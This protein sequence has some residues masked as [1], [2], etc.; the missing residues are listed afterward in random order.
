[1]V[2]LPAFGVTIDAFQALRTIGC[3]LVDTT[4]GSV[5][6]V[7][8]RVEAYGRDG[9]TRSSMASTS[10]RRRGHGVADAEVRWHYIIVRHML[11]A[12]MVCDFIEGRLS[13]AELMSS[14][15]NAVS[16]DFDPD[17][18]LRRIGVA[19]QTT[20]LARES[21]AI[22]E[23]VGMAMDRARGA[24]ARANDSERSIRSA[25]PPRNV[26]TRSLNC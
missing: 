22:G 24:E 2:L 9:Y 15:A 17:Q 4:C 11:E 21:L 3:V 16:P 10:T 7:W 13:R 19:N 5:L 26:R 23:E 8:K 20:M 18:H 25:A 6:N 14:F 12:R 1:V